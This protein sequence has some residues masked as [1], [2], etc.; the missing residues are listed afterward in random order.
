[1]STFRL[2]ISSPDG[3]VWEGD[4]Y[5]LTVRGVEGELAVLAGHVPF[6]TAVKPCDCKIEL[7]DGTELYGHTEGGILTVSHHNTTLL[8]GTF[9]MTE[10]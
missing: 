6:V 9:R 1:M 2:K 7:E 5:M 4:A 8:S 3:N 10:Q